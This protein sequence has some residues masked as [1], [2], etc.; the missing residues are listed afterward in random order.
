MVFLFFFHNFEVVVFHAPPAISALSGFHSHA[1]VS[2]SIHMRK[3]G[4]GAIGVYKNY[5]FMTI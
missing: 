1:A 2:N 5:W 4:Y 3:M